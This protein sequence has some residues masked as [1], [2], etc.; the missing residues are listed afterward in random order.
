MALLAAVFTVGLGSGILGGFLYGLGSG[1]GA[2]GP[3]SPTRAADRFSGAAVDVAAALR[4]VEPAVV[5]IT[6][7]SIVYSGPYNQVA[8]GAGTGI[9]VSADGEVLTNAHVVASATSIEVVFPGAPGTHPATLLGRDSAADVALIKVA[10]VSGLHPA[11]LAPAARLAVGDQVL[12]IGNAL[13]LE[14]G[15]TVTMGIVSAL[16]RAL[17][18]ETGS[19]TGMIQ[20]DAAISSGNSGGP[21]VDAAGEVVG[22]NTAVAASSPTVEA[23]NIGFAIPIA[24]ALD[25]VSPFRGA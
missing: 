25:A 22:I 13:A 21:L 18:T 10:G 17:Q 9:V 16:S 5:S 4:Q 15:P 11:P 12:A 23:Q 20:T 6:T 1:A 19:L 14:G 2:S 3:S 7:R 24:A 8:Q